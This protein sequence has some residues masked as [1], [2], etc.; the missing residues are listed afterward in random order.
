MTN[1]YEVSKQIANRLDIN[2]IE[3][4]N[5]LNKKYKELNELD[6]LDTRYYLFSEITFKEIKINNKNLITMINKLYETDDKINKYIVAKHTKYPDYKNDINNKYNK[7]KTNIFQ[8]QILSLIR[9]IIK[10]NKNSKHIDLLEAFTKVI[11]NYG[12]EHIYGLTQQLVP[13]QK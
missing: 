10:E 4:Y 2:I 9:K 8:L 12:L 6:K 3:E 13:S 5:K 1:L 11:N 7:F